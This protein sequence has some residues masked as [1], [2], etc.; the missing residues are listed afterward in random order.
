MFSISFVNQ[1]VTFDATG[2][3]LSEACAQAGFPLNL[4]CGGRGTCGKCRVVIERGGVRE[5]VLACREVIQSDMSVYLTDEQLSRSASIMTE[6]HSSQRVQLAPAISKKCATRQELLPEHCGAYLTAPDIQVLRKFSRL[7]A[8][9]EISQI[10]FV[11]YLNE[12]I[13]VEPGDTTDQMYGGAVDIGTTSVVFYGYDLRT[14]KLLHTE[15]ALNGQITRGADVISRIL[16]TRQDPSGLSELQD[17]ICQTINDLLDGVEAR[18]PGFCAHLYHMVLCGNSTMQHLFLGLDPS[19]LSADPFV[20]VTARPVSLP[21]GQ[22][23]LHM[24][25]AG[26]V[27]FLPLLGGFVGAD[28]ASVLL[29]LPQDSKRCMMVDLGTNGEIAVGGSGSYQVASTACG[30]ALEGG[31]IACGMRG[32]NGAIEKISLRDDRIHL[33]IIGDTD[34]VGLCGSAIID[35][36]AELRR[37]EVIDIT[38]RL[39]PADEFR[40]L[41]PDS[42]LVRHLGKTPEGSNCF[43]FV[44]GE[45]PIYL[46]Q[47]DVRQIQ[48]AKSSIYSGCIT[49]LEQAGMTP[50]D[51]TAFYLAGAFGNY[52]DVDNALFIGLLPPVPRDRIISVGNGAGQGVQLCLL[53]HQQL[54]RCRTL[55]QGVEHVELATSPKFMEEYIMNMNFPR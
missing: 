33:Q 2:G 38:G 32:T 36:I 34:P 9:E 27:Q 37:V 8:D 12:I 29:S 43:F 41:H 5:E 22:T 28:T 30:P 11:Q 52:I 46:D 51:V 3:F 23:G 39:L 16:H 26:R 1:G 15:S 47:H 21:A 17:R 6:G 49:L 50:E 53:D 55:P 13:D 42:A 40:S 10:T 4:V 18:I 54:S 35:A 44:E 25:A 19:G 24:P 31:N 14:G 45:Q 20:N 48:L 7:I